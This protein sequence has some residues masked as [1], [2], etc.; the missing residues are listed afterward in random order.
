[1]RITIERLDHKHA[2]EKYALERENKRYREALVFATE[3]LTTILEVEN[4]TKEQIAECA[5]SAYNKINE[6]LEDS[7]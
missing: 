4:L 5:G 1:M 3:E 7:I 2:S 6:A